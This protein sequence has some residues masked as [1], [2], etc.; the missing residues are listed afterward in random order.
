MRK[1]LVTLV[2]VS[3][4]S[5]SL[6]GYSQ[7][8][9]VKDMQSMEAAMSEIQKGILYNNKELVIKG[10]ENL[11]KASV[12]IEVAPKDS[13]DFSVRFAKRQSENI[14]KYAQKIAKNIKDNHKHAA[15]KNYTKVLNECISC[16]N[17]IR[18]WD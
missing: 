6:Y 14:M 2:T 13:M 8:D 17:K 12:N 10:V 16:H 4:L 3:M 5:I 15:T 11:K 9:R 1:I 7:T 18:K